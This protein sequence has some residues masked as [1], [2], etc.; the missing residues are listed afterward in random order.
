[1]VLPSFAEGLPV[2]L[3]E[4]FA[5]GRPVLSTYVGGIAELVEPGTNGW[6]VP[7]GSVSALAAAMREILAA[8]KDE[9]VRRARRGARRVSQRHDARREAAR[10]L[11]LFAGRNPRDN[12]IDEPPV[13]PA[14][15]LPDAQ[16][17]LLASPVRS[18][19]CPDQAKACFP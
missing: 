14:D 13:A 10:L 8:D 6:L 18:S 1:L 19:D 2:V 4:A 17:Q 7:P 16:A 11:R 15:G 5:V 9:L 12:E 3:M